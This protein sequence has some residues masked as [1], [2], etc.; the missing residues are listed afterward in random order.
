[1][2]GPTNVISLL[3]NKMGWQAARTQNLNFNVANAET[4][5]FK[6]R[7]LKDF[8]EVLR[9]NASK[10]RETTSALAPIVPVESKD[11]NRTFDEVSREDEMLTITENSTSYSA[12][13]QFFK[14]YLN[15]MKTVL[16]KA[17]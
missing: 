13:L 9:R 14:K 12:N 4:P 7:E 6:R 15:L 16:G 17:N 11:I 3:A 10:L 8:H 2:I 5:G 1:M